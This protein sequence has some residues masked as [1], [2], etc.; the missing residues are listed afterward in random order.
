[1]RR[2]KR[3]PRPLHAA[4][5]LLAVLLGLTL[6]RLLCG[7]TDL[8]TER[9][10]LRRAQRQS[11]RVPREAVDTV[12][13]FNQQL[14]AVWDGSEIQA[15][16]A[17]WKRPLRRGYSYN[18]AGERGLVLMAE[19]LI[20]DYYYCY[21]WRDS[22]DY[23][24][25]CPGTVMTGYRVHDTSWMSKYSLPLLVK[26]SDPAAL[27]GE[28]TVRGAI[29]DDVYDQPFGVT[30]DARRENPWF[31]TFLLET[32]WSVAARAFHYIEGGTEEETCTAEA[33]I[34]WYDADGNELYRQQ[35]ELI[36][37]EGREHYG[38]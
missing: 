2:R 11:L 21:L 33:E 12:N 16:Q 28:I 22:R 25:G 35:I 31:F 1:M 15:Y 34:V 13:V 23:G 30:A 14:F 9:Q 26:N 27:R 7:P 29:R 19:P 32:D 3:L 4:L 38:A 17:W 37:S 8:M 10:A 20:R 24:W 5:C 18:S 36:E 6:V